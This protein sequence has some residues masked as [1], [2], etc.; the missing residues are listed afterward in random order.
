MNLNLLPAD[1]YIVLNKTIISEL[2]KKIITTLYQPIIGY[3]AVSLY[4]TLLN[5]LN[6]NNTMSIEY[7]HHHLMTLLQIDLGTL[8]KNREKLEA[9]GLIKTFIKKDNINNY[10][11]EIYSPISANELFNHPILNIVLY[12]NVG[13][14]EY[15]RLV[16]IFKIPRVTL[17]DYEEITKTFTQVFKSTQGGV[18]DVKEDIAKRSQNNFEVESQVDFSLLLASI[19]KGLLNEKAFNKDTRALINNIAY[20]YDL[21]DLK[22]QSLVRNVVNEK[23]LI[24]KDE[25]RKQARNL[26]QFNNAGKLPTLIYKTQPEYLKK[27]T[28]DN[29]NWAKMVYTFETTTPYDYLKSKQKGAEP[30]NRD[31]KI[32]ESLLIDM[33]LNP[34]VVNVLISYVLKINDQKLNKAYLETI[35]AQWKRVGIETVEEAMIYSEKEHKKISKNIDKKVNYQKNK[36]DDT[37]LPDWFNNE[38]KEVNISPEE[39]KE[40]QDLLDSF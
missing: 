27:A 17:K 2:D 28:G 8:H 4:L 14:K 25:L 39:Q 18:L 11:Y 12:N 40:L 3:G 30:T 20:A 38:V 9:I 16:S 26:Y 35:A 31:L 33:K 36:E 21:D 22:I 34:G 29:S 13:K 6:D 24:D 1:S 15:D 19:P 23:G 7:T 5:E 32:I 37:K 10:V